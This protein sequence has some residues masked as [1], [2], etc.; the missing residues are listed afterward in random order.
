[1]HDSFLEYRDYDVR[2]YFKSGRVWILPVCK[3]TGKVSINALYQNV[4]SMW[5]GR[6]ILA[7]V[8]GLTKQQLV[9]QMHQD[10]YYAEVRRIEELPKPPGRSDSWWNTQVEGMICDI[11]IGYIIPTRWDLFVNRLEAYGWYQFLASVAKMIVGMSE[12]EYYLGL[13]R[14]CIHDVGG[15]YVRTECHDD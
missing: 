9:D 4:K 11:E 8:F 14:Q 7:A 5:A 12:E 3:N 2:A 15:R 6:K 13:L 1:M 10:A